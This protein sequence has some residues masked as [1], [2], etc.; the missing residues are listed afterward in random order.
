MQ[1]VTNALGEFVARTRFSDLPREAIERGR[2]CLLHN[3]GVALAGRRA[4]PL[5]H[6]LV[7]RH[8]AQ[9]AESTLLWDGSKVSAEGAALA[10]AALMHA[11]TQDD[12]HFPAS[13]HTGSSVIPAALAMAEAVQATGE[14][15]LL[16][17][18]LGYEIAARVGME[19][20]TITTGRGFRAT[21][22]YGVFGA[23]AASAR[24]MGLTADRTAAALA[25]AANLAGGLGQ[26]WVEGTS[27]WRLQVGIVGRNGIFAAR[28][29]AAGASGAAASLEGVAGFYQ[30]VAGTVE[31]ARSALASL[32]Q[33]W[34]VGEVTL[35][36]Y[37]VC[38]IQQSPVGMMIALASQHD[39]KPERVEEIVLELNPYEAAYPGTDSVG[40]F[41]DQGGTLM[42]GQFCMALALMDRKATID[43][44]FRFDDP[45]LSA[46]TRRV[47]IVANDALA[48]LCSRLTVVTQDGRRMSSE[49]V[50][51]P[52]THKFSFDEDAELVRRLQPEMEIPA[53]EL[54][55]LIGL[56]RDIERQPNLDAL[57]ACMTSRSAAH[58]GAKPI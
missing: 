14:A 27:E 51:S 36:P 3:L 16:S 2:T 52:S 41:Q 35:K 25:F 20:D 32:G 48:P 34:Q 29:A 11:R 47:R 44:L 22:I 28:I 45:V 40:P 55:R 46:L 31:H 56:V 7:A 54:E 9:P 12:T 50:S 4:E 24:L 10:N 1:T 39:L 8:Y 58:P 38:A 6:G 21:S 5:A 13:T 19:H 15:F 30:A 23:A 26:T 43:G 18:L 33:H 57:V 17:V 49:T 42:S 53:G 37:P